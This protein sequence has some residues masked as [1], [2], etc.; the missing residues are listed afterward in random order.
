MANI[1]AAEIAAAR[2]RGAQEPAIVSAR[3]II[4]LGKTP[5]RGGL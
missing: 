1:T 4:S 2:K 5:A 3:L